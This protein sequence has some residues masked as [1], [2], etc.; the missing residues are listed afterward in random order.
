MSSIRDVAKLA[1]VS[2]ATVSRVMNGT[3]KVDPEK[4]QRVQ[5]VIKDTGFVPNEVARSLFKKSAKLLGLMIPNLQNPFFTQLS[6]QIEEAAERRGYH[7][8]LCAVGQDP[9][10]V[11]H[12]LQLLMAMNADG[13]VLAVNCPDIS[14]LLRGCPI[15]IVAVDCLENAE[16]IAACIHCDY[17]AGGR[18]AMEHLLSCGCRKIVCIK[19]DQNIFSARMRYAGYRDVCREQG[20]PEYTLHCDYDFSAGLE[21]T[22][23]LL[24]LYPDADGILAC[25]D[26]VAVSTFKILH[27]KNIQVPEQVQLVGFDDIDL[28]QLISPE[29]TTI[30]QPIREM[31]QCAV[32]YLVGEQA[33]THEEKARILPVTLIVRET[34]GK[35]P[36]GN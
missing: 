30:H 3:A 10:K 11:R 24:K 14:R 18:M 29:L 35:K 17:Y 4:Q 22:E 28:T 36:R 2:P 12:A 32:G 16:N 20:I 27:K 31:A 15:P 7:V 5:Q 9:E 6:A 23:T 25:N 34:T 26:I 33:G 8:F 1:G 21:M 13:V 19:G